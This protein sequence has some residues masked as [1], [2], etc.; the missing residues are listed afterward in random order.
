MARYKVISCGV[1]RGLIE[2]VAERCRNAIDVEYLE[3]GMHA[4]PK[5]LNEQLREAVRRAEEHP[6][7]AVLL[8]YGLCNRGTINLK[9]RRLPL[10]IPRAHD[11][12]A[13]FLG[14]LKRYREEFSRYPGTFYFCQYWID[15]KG[16]PRLRRDVRK[17]RRFAE[18]KE[19]Y[20]EENARH[21]I[22]FYES[23]RRN[24]Q[25]A[26]YISFDHD[27]PEM[28]EKFIPAVRRLAAEEGWKFEEIRGDTSLLEDMMNGRWDDERFVVVKPRQKVVLGTQDRVMEAMG[29]DMPR[30]DEAPVAK[31]QRAEPAVSVGASERIAMGIDAGGT[32]TDSVIFDLSRNKLLCK[33]KAL[34]TK[35][36]L[37]DGILASV[38]G[39]D[40]SLFPRVSF[41]CVS[42]TLAT[43]AVV[44]GKGD[45]VG[46]IIL[47]P[48]IFK[49]SDIPHEPKVVLRGRMGM[50]GNEIAPVD[51]DEV[52]RAARLLV[53]EH[54]AKAIAVSGF[55]AVSNPKHELL[56]RRVVSETYDIPIV[57]GHELSMGL[58]FIR[59]ANTAVL[60]AK[61]M[62]I[63]RELI[64]SVKKALR[65]RGIKVPVMVVRCDGTLMSERMA[66]ERPI[67]T[68]LS[69]PA[70]SA[71]GAIHLSGL[72][73]A[74]V[75]DMG[76]TTSDVTKLKDGD[77]IVSP[78]G[79]RVGGW[80]TN[81]RAAD[82]ITAGLGGDSYVRLRNIDEIT[83]GPERVVPLSL[84]A[85]NHPDVLNE[86]ERLEGEGAA[87]GS[88]GFDSFQ[89]TDFF[90][91][92]REPDGVRLNS[93]E[94]EIVDIVT[95]KP[96]SAVALARKL[97]SLHP[98][99][100]R[101][102]R[103]ERMGIVQRSSLTPTDA[104]HA[105]GEFDAWNAEA[106]KRGL[107]I[108]ARMFGVEEAFLA[109][110][111]LDKVK[112]E[113]ALLILLREF[114]NVRGVEDFPGC[115][116]CKA[117]VDNLFSRG[118]GWDFISEIRLKHPIVAI[119]APVGAYMPEVGQVLN[120][121][122]VIPRDAD[123]ANA[124]GAAVADVI[125]EEEVTIRPSAEGGYSLHSRV[126]R[127]EFSSLADA[128]RYAEQQVM[129]IL[130]ARGAKS[131]AASLNVR[132]DVLDRKSRAADGSE[133]LLETIVRGRIASK[134][135]V[136]E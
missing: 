43:N 31:E 33:S 37:I 103:L 25:R 77:V 15:N 102:A 40:E 62:P 109:E 8:A 10:V 67:E 44:E 88:A 22:E 87:S 117:M 104:L 46:L 36:D 3:A 84:L 108:Y 113:L 38:D 73:S 65:E 76:G 94:R 71:R 51:E 83:I 27:R 56:V 55:A 127:R 26:A 126:E 68:I 41:V 12:I 107:R 28:R 70:A 99:L 59:R 29:V 30:E 58:N 119:G 13:I 1:F 75:I 5:E 96:V 134:P 79:A 95:E 42:T 18:L 21:I 60:N 85:H 91:L 64:T 57:C 120:T 45:T 128:R 49:K 14:S 114:V 9:P 20:G 34:T 101:T 100:V 111:I 61:L 35:H 125:I 16:A 72:Q 80:K 92:L 130:R 66:Y 7:D 105:L 131:G 89:P 132:V 11:C 118:E 90:L 115:E 24:Y 81:V 121:P 52:R 63:I 106:A 50:D 32:Y 23:W 129:R 47:P 124:I 116:V 122:V 6:Y 97:R 78:E 4:R 136:P 93:E 74:T 19:K 39:L 123:V 53:E 17:S 48:P 98:S 69:G 86:L 110:R 133:V 112:R 54:G 2:K 135:A 82:I